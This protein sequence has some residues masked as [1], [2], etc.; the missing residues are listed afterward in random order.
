MRGEI[1]GGS[2]PPQFVTPT[3]VCGSTVNGTVGVAL[4]FTVKASDVNAGDVVTLTAGGWPV[5]SLMTPALPTAGNPVQSVLSWTPPNSAVGAHLITFTA[6]DL[7]GNA[8]SGQIT[9]MA[10]ECY[11][12]VGRAAGQ[13]RLILGGTLFSSQ[14][15]SVRFIYPV[16]MTDRPALRIPDLPTAITFQRGAVMSNPIVFLSSPDQWSN[17]LH[18][19]V[20]PGQ[21]VQGALYGS[22]NGTRTLQR[23]RTRGGNTSPFT[24]DGM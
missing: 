16:T 12:F 7:A 8:T 14:V 9:I 3:Q 18:I 23:S 2:N 20:Y 21:V 11:R 22:L 15:A 10:A 19:A 1:T 13:S 4:S 6:T 17:R 24:I 5:G